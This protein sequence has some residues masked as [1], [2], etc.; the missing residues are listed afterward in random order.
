[1][2]LFR[3]WAEAGRIGDGLRFTSES[4]QSKTTHHITGVAM[5]RGSF[6]DDVVVLEYVLSRM[7]IIRDSRAANRIYLAQ[8]QFGCLNH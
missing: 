2:P 3:D 5:H 1:M 7:H 6:Q 4:S 8:S